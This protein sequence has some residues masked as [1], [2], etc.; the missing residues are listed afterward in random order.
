MRLQP[1]NRFG[2]W[3]VFQQPV[4][5]GNVSQLTLSQVAALATVGSAQVAALTGYAANLTADQKDVI[6]GIVSAG[7]W[8]ALG[9]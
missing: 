8:T 2:R 4:S 1:L 6:K 9:L 3:G 7:D 5:A